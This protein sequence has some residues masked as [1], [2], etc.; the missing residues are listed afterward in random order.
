MVDEVPIVSDLL[1]RVHAYRVYAFSGMTVP[2]VLGSQVPAGPSSA[3]EPSWRR[4]CPV[5]CPEASPLRE[6]PGPPRKSSNS[7]RG[8]RLAVL[9]RQPPCHGTRT[10]VKRK[11]PRLQQKGRWGGGGARIWWTVRQF[12]N[13][14]VTSMSQGGPGILG[15]QTWVSR[16]HIQVIALVS[17]FRPDSPMT[18]MAMEKI[19][20]RETRR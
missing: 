12:A 3:Y 8:R 18:S 4:E 6:G 19:H 14:I 10:C 16:M 13:I 20:E 1:F 11:L 7:W 17:L 5:R 2:G 9:S 15:G